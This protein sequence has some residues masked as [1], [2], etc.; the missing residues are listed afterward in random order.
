M[1]HSRAPPPDALRHKLDDI[2]HRNDPSQPVHD[3]AKVRGVA[4]DRPAHCLPHLR[5]L[6]RI[7]LKGRK[8]PGKS[9][10][11]QDGIL[12]GAATPAPRPAAAPSPATGRHG[13]F[14][15]R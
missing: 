2:S 3:Q 5:H 12:R 10:R 8:R 7:K 15:E 1:S 9:R 4:A 14:Q 11:R 6:V 13:R